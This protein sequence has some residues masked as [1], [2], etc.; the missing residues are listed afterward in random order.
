MAFGLLRCRDGQEIKVVDITPEGK[1]KK[2]VPFQFYVGRRSKKKFKVII[3]K[4]AKLNQ[5]YRFI[6]ADVDS[7]DLLYTSDSVVATNDAPATIAKRLTIHLENT[8]PDSAVYVM[9]TT[10][11][12]IRYAVSKD[13]PSPE[14]EGTPIILE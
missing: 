4:S 7:F 11:N 13:T 9:A 6:S 8:E 12:T 1:D 5:W 10:S 14:V 3:D 2:Q